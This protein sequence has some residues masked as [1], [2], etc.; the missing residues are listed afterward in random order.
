MTAAG[1]AGAAGPTAPDVTRRRWVI[2]LVAVLVAVVVG[3]LVWSGR[4]VP[5]DAAP[6]GSPTSA[7]ATLEAGPTSSSTSGGPGVAPQPSADPPIAADAPRIGFLGD[8]LTEGVGAPPERGY[9]WQTAEQLGWPL[10]V[11]DGVSGSGFVAPGLGRPMPERVDGVV[12]ADPDVVVV[13]GGTNDA[14][15]GYPADDVEDAA[16]ALL[17]ELDTDLPDATVVVLG[18]FTS[19]LTGG[20]GGDATAAAVRAAA[21]AAGVEY[22]DATELLDRATADSTQWRRYL[23]ADG[24]HPNELGYEVIATALAG[25]LRELVG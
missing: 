16:A 17:D 4:S 7:A 2:G 3:A 1:R 9:A 6:A 5:D 18:P 25:E 19:V 12:A 13:A 8:S 14:F 21:E 23:S 24:L 15:R 10:A 20:A 11:V 22:V